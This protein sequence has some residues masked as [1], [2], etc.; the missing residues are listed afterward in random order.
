MGLEDPLA[1]AIARRLIAQSDEVRILLD[2]PH[3]REG[4]R[5]R[6]VYVAVGDA[7]DEDFVW[8]A[9]GGVRTVV[10]GA[11]W[12]AGDPGPVL[13]AGA[14]RAGVGRFIVLAA[15]AP[16]SLPEALS[17]E[18]TELVVLRLPKKKFL[19]RTQISPE[20]IAEAVDAADDLAVAPNLDLDLAEPDAW[21]EL[22]LSPPAAPKA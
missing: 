5:Q 22:R 6:G 21:S 18:G 12:V 8:R 14:K 19:G 10:A 13:V 4:W 11:G 20:D 3:D 9:A 2:S 7:H 15:G 1:A 17:E 16:P